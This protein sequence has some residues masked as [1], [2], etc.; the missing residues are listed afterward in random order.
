MKLENN[1]SVFDLIVTQT[2]SI[3]NIIEFIELNGFENVNDNL[4]G[5]EFEPYSNIVFSQ[6]LKNNNRIISTRSLNTSPT[7]LY[8]FNFENFN[9][10]FNI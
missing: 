6:N 8:Q 3:D 5:K 2:G 1:I 9:N 10:D 7:L 4:L